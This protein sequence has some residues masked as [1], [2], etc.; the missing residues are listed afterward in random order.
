MK[1]I[2]VLFLSL[3]ALVFVA[4][5]KDKDIRDILDKEKISSEFNIVEE[6]EKYFEFKDKDDNRDVFRIFMYEK[7]SSVDFKNPKKIDSLEEGY[8]EQ[9]CDII[10]KDKDTIMIGI[11][12]PEVGYGYNIHNFDNSKTTL[13]IIVAIGSQDELSE[14]DLFEILKEAKSFIK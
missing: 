9:G 8:F 11:F 1:K 2:L 6:S 14:K 7:I 10:Y 3:L 4:C 12:D 5:G 13:E